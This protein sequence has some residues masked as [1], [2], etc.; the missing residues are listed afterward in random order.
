MSNLDN[1]LASIQSL[2]AQGDYKSALPICLKAV[3]LGSPEA[4]RI[5]GKMFLWGIVNKKQDTTNAFKWWKLAADN[6]DAEACF[7]VGQEYSLG[8]IVGKNPKL[9][10]Y[11]ISKSVKKYYLTID[12]KKSPKKD[13]E[14][15]GVALGHLAWFYYS[16]LGCIQN[17]NLAFYYAEIGANQFNDTMC[18]LILGLCYFHGD[19]TSQN[20]DISKAYFCKGAA[21]GDET[22]KKAIKDYFEYVEDYGRDENIDENEEEIE[23]EDFFDYPNEPTLDIDEDDDNLYADDVDAMDDGGGL[24]YGY[25]DDP[26][27]EE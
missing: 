16:G 10:F 3:E 8:K 12:E 2:I 4:Q 14:N 18:M 5:L 23:D 9:A 15:Y 21:L 11:Y 26:D 1:L 7:L 19:G 20:K 25:R 6:D 17:Y 27:Y 13:C 22:C 24:D